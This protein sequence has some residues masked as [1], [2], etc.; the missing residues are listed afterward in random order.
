MDEFPEQGDQFDIAT[1]IRRMASIS[2]PTMRRRQLQRHV[3]SVDAATFAQHLEYIV[4]HAIR[5]QAIAAEL[6]LS[7]CEY[8]HRAE[9]RDAIAL[10][11]V[12]LEA[13][14]A[15]YSSLCWMLLRPEPYRAI[16][17]LI[18]RQKGKPMSLGER[19]AEAVGWD[20]TKLERLIHD[21]D[22][23][24]LEK[25]CKNPRIQEQHIMAIASRRPTLPILLDVLVR[26]PRWGRR[27]RV[28]ETL[29]QNPYIETGTALCFLPTVPATALER[30][31]CATEL[32]PAVLDF[33][34]YLLAAR[35]KGVESV[36]IP[37]YGQMK[38]R[39]NGP[40]DERSWDALE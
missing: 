12:N 29:V 34:R 38:R 33:S 5:G 26:E 3:L 11:A 20:P 21:N 27:A 7:V 19:K 28:R 1:L 31:Q 23:T 14:S 9:G 17:K 36:E 8:I 40:V 25:L 18:L 6:L 39:E 37:D 10:E 32:H 13:R 4:S 24:V 30:I 35:Y 22:P 15:G 2:D 16:D